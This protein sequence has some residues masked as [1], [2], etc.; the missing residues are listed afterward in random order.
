MK[1]TGASY[2]MTANYFGILDV[3]II[4]NWHQKFLK[5]GVGPYLDRKDGLETT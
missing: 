1:T 4:A 5:G 3:G 2:S